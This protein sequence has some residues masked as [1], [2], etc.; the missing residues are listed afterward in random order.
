MHISTKIIKTISRFLKPIS[1]LN[2]RIYQPKGGQRVIL[3]YHGISKLPKFN[4][5][6]QS[7]FR[8]QISLLKKKI[9]SSPAFC[10]GREFKVL[11]STKRPI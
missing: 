3:M 5:V 6:T 11:L 9:Y 1:N 10:P 7:L 2:N 4:C 8:E